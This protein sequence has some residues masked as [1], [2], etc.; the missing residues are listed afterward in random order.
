MKKINFLKSWTSISHSF[1]I[2][3]SIKVYCCYLRKSYNFPFICILEVGSST[4]D[5]LCFRIW[6]LPRLFEEIRV[7]SE[8]EKS[9]RENFAFFA[10][11]FFSR[12]FRISFARVLNFRF[13]REIS[14]QSVSQKNAKFSRNRKHENFAKK[15][16]QAKIMV[17]HM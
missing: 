9:F 10:K 4:P 11:H 15:C 6:E 5:P 3:Q 1:F 12:P 7:S 2:T 8:K 17:E 14:L 13:I 16:E